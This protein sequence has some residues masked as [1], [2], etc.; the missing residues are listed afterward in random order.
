L[1]PVQP[2]TK[3]RKKKRDNERDSAV[4]NHVLYKIME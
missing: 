1:K 3:E 4:K 2:K